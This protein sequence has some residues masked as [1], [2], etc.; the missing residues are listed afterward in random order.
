MVL[1]KT[2]QLTPVTCVPNHIAVIVQ[3]TSV[4]E[5]EP[6]GVD[7]EIFISEDTLGPVSGLGGDHLGFGIMGGGRWPSLLVYSCRGFHFH[8]P[9]QVGT[10][11]IDFR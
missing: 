5:K 8:F 7:F 2:I 1:V 9:C 3:Q 11:G 10:R 6:Q 4:F